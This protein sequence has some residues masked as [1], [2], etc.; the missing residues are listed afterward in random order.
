MNG[1]DFT[2]GTKCTRVYEDDSHQTA[3][4]KSASHLEEWIRV[5]SH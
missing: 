4:L 1:H 2:N 3:R 5:M